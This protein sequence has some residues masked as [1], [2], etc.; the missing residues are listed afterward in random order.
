MA[1][2]DW[3]TGPFVKELRKTINNDFCVQT[4]KENKAMLHTQM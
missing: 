3:S 2:L 4:E 1:L